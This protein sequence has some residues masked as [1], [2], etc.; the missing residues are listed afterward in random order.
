LDGQT[1]AK[2]FSPTAWVRLAVQ[3][4][5]LVASMGG[6]V[7]NLKGELKDDIAGVKNDI[8][9][10]RQQTSDTQSE[11]VRLQSE[12]ANVTDGLAFARNR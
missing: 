4:L 1:E 5:A 10:L 8:A 3:V 12:I 2:N 7:Y 6:A 9:G 11:V